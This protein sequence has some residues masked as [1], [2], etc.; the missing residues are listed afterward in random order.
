MPL[1]SREIKTNQHDVVCDVCGRTL[2]RGERAEPFLAGGSRRQ[3]CELCVNRAMHEGW[4]RESGGDDLGVRPSRAESRGMSIFGRMRQRREREPDLE[5]EPVE[6]DPALEAELAEHPVVTER[7]PPRPAP[8]DEQVAVRSREPRQVHAVPTNADMKMQ[9]AVDVFNR[10]QYPRTVAGVARSLGVP[11]I[12]VRTL[13]DQPSVVS[14]TVMWELSW[15]RYQVDLSDEA[16]GARR[17]GQGAELEELAEADRVV[18]AT[19]DERGHLSL[20]V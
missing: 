8:A 7:R 1:H 10:S 3:V 2:L 5:E 11:E 18:N 4:I 12:G 20:G 17:E 9:R 19:A 16:G 6:L 15:Y 14:I 13:P